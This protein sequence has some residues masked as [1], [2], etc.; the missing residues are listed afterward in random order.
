MPKNI[1]VFLFA[2]IEN[3]MYGK[4]KTFDYVALRDLCV[5][6]FKK[7][8][9]GLDEI[10]PLGGRFK[11]YHEMFRFKYE[12]L[13]SLWFGKQLGY[14]CNILYADLDNLCVKPVDIFSAFEDM[15]LFCMSSDSGYLDSLRGT[16]SDKLLTGVEP[17]FVANVKYFP[18]TMSEEVWA[19]GD[20]IASKWIDVWSFECLV[21]N[22]MF[23]AQNIS[24]VSAYHRPEYSYQ[25]P[26]RGKYRNSIPFDKAKILHFHSTRG[27]REAIKRME[28]T[29]KAVNTIRGV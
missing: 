17:W 23:H 18:A 28:E 26:V 19:A 21:Y 12:A 3:A 13:K 14:R 16:V 2:Q 8:L 7:N 25:V 4:A 27:S 6:S 9:I 22:T 15:Q 20:R 11:D 24:N 1:F 5:E 29:W 10:W